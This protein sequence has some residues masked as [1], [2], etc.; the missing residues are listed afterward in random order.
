MGWREQIEARIGALRHPAWG[1]EHCRRL[2][3]TMRKIVRSERLRADDDVLFALA[4]LHDIGTYE[5]FSGLAD[6][7][8]ACAAIA[9]DQLLAEAGFPVDKLE[10]VSRVIRAHSFEE[11]PRSSMEA[12]I[13]H[14]ADM[15][16][17]LGAIG[18][19]RLLSIVGLEEWVPEPRAAVGLALDFASTLPDRL[20]YESSRKMARDRIAETSAFTDALS[21]ETGDL[22]WV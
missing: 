8:P 7:P 1:P 6:S 22:A 19:V 4:W 2:Y 21:A 13:L 16:E 15:L 14:D 18:L 17:F 11:A 9:A 3:E 10:T 20:Y 5:E 12:R